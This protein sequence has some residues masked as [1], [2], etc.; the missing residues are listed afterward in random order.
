MSLLAAAQIH[1][2]LTFL[3][4]C[5][6]AQREP[7]GIGCCMLAARVEGNFPLPPASAVLLPWTSDGC[8]FQSGAL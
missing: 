1:L 5:A 2:A 8:G 3:G 4:L 7:F 6:A